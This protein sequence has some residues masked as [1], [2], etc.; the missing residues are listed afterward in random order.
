MNGYDGSLMGNLLALPAFQK[1]FDA[2]ILGV[3]T[4]LI[5]AMLQIGS[6]SALPFVSP[7]ADYFGRKAVC[8]YIVCLL[9]GMV[10]MN[11]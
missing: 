10:L 4:G 2:T 3:K 8:E 1:Q 6:V 7:A 9:R 5:S 11:V